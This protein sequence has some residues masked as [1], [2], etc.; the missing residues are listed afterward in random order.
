MGQSFLSSCLLSYLTAKNPFT[1]SEWRDGFLKVTILR[2][3][4]LLKK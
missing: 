1:S 4:E 2:G 3:V